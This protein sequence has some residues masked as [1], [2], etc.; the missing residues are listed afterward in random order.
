[1]SLSSN[2][3][4]AFLE[5]FFGLLSCWWIYLFL[6][7]QLF[8]AFHHSLIYNLKE[9]INVH[10]FLHIYKLSNP[11]PIHT[12]QYYKI[13][14]TFIL[15]SWYLY[16]YLSIRSNTVNLGF[17]WL[18]HH[19]LVLYSPAFQYL[20]MPQIFLWKSSHSI[21]FQWNRTEIH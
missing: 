4:C 6:G 18:Q 12:A 2:Y 20:S 15:D 9:L 11:I 3:S 1:M 13:L 21:G 14:P 17:I 5:M 19:F 16:I 8:K 10:I 7:I